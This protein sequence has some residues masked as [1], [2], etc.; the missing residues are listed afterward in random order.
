M[1]KR[2]LSIWLLC[3]MVAVLMVAG[4]YAIAVEYGSQNDPLV[5]LSYIDQVL[6]PEAKAE[7]DRQ[8]TQALNEYDR[9]L[10]EQ[11]GQ[12]RDYV[13][14]QLQAYA[15]GAVDPQLVE[16]IAQT[17]VAELGGATFSGG[18]VQWSVIQVEAGKTITCGV[19][20]QAILRTGAAVCVA[21]GSPGLLDVSD[22]ETLENG[23]NLIAN[24]MYTVTVQGRGIRVTQNAA[25]LISGDYSIS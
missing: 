21:S 2:K 18:S 15:Q 16:Q 23:G 24:H 14:R 4:L 17:V 9:S 5:T 7:I 19:G 8:V 20:C 22:A 1:K 10:E 11:A 3:G 25:L 6:L 12:I 13:D